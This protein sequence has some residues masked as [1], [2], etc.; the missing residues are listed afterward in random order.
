[1]ENTQW[2][3]LLRP[4]TTVKSLSISEEFTPRV[5]P[6][7]QKLAGERIM[8]V[9]PTVQSISLPESSLSGPVKEAFEQF[10]T[11]RQLS[12]HFVAVNPQGKE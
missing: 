11:A 2:L 9:L 3:D 5:V 10:L 7:L 6:T 4:F 1:V 8:D 12:G